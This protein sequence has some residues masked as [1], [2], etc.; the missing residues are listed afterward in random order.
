MALVNWANDDDC[1]LILFDVVMAR[2][3]VD[4][5]RYSRTFA[6]EFNSL[7]YSFKAESFNDIDV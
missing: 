7:L 6:C 5:I 3:V 2:L 4:C 1:N